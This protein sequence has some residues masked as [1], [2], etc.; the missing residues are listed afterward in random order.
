LN[1]EELK[2]VVEAA[3]N[4]PD[5]DMNDWGECL[6]GSYLKD[7]TD[8]IFF[9][10]W[11]DG[12]FGETRYL[13]GAQYFDIS[14]EDAVNLF[15]MREEYSDMYEEFPNC[16]ESVFYEMRKDACIRVRNLA[17]DRLEEFIWEKENA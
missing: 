13:A 4:N 1:I 3:K 14:A 15:G 2:K 10:L 12:T 6:F 16:T 7:K 8:D 9:A 11:S 5:F 17:I